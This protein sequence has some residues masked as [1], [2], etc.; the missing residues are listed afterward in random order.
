MTGLPTELERGL[1]VLKEYAQ[2]TPWQADLLLY[3]ARMHEI[4]QRMQ[5]FGR[6]RDSTHERNEVWDALNRLA[7]EH[8]NLSFND[9]TQGKRP[10][11]GTALPQQPP[12]PPAV[13]RV[14]TMQLSHLADGQ[15]EVRVLDSPMGQAKAVVALP[16]RPDELVA[17]LKALDQ[18]GDVR[19]EQMKLL[20]ALGLL[21]QGHGRSDMLEQV[22][23]HL[24]QT[25]FTG[26]VGTV[27][28][29][30]LNQ[31]R[32]SGQG[33]AIQLRF[34]DHDANLA[35]FPWELI[36]DGRR[37]LCASQNIEMSRSIS[38]PE[39]ATL[40]LVQ[41]PLNL[42]SVM[43][44]PTDLAPVMLT[45]N[46][47]PVVALHAN[48]TSNIFRITT[49]D[50]ATGQ[51]LIKQL[52]RQ[53]VHILHIAAHGVF[54]RQCPITHCGKRHYPHIERCEVCGSDMRT[55]QPRG[56]L[57][58]QRDDGRADWIGSDRLGTL[59]TGT[60]VRL[61]VL[62]ACSTAAVRDGSLFS[63]LG[64]AL[65][66]AGIPAVVSMQL[67]FSLDAADS[68]TRSFYPTLARTGSVLAAVRAG[69]RQL[70]LGREWFIPVLHMRSQDGDGQLF[71][72]L[73]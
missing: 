34:D 44:Q 16:Y 24:Y 20:E 42:L 1:D 72:P 25:L 18:A 53:P 3:E 49:L 23:Q 52:D 50:S 46:H 12:A 15:L 5:R 2:G 57:A 37:Y 32:A 58:L 43:A 7:L 61:V 28:T 48:D 66:E 17:V 67:R 35:R 55:V 11:P 4:I 26:D 36:H 63:G 40:L 8:L 10:S 21:Q 41:P 6:S 59:L 68:F 9:L 19:P 22:G 70:F 14:F 51:T 45:P 31:A 27:F 39:A 60:S 71:T 54:A 69:R 62:A 29:A 47:E 33:M 13:A 30:T 73:M 64:Q 56:Y 38:Y 65:I